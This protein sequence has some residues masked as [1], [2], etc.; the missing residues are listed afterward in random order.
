MRWYLDFICLP[1]RFVLRL[2]AI[3]SSCQNSLASRDNTSCVSSFGSFSLLPKGLCSFLSTQRY[4]QREPAFS[5]YRVIPSR[6]PERCRNPILAA[7][8]GLA[9][10]S[11]QAV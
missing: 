5:D 11:V 8:T 7:L 6:W 1:V 10:S 2:N 9:R 3:K 4:D